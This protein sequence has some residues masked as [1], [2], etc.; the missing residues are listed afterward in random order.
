MPFFSSLP[1]GVQDLIATVVTFAVALAWLRI[2]DTLA[3]RGLIESRLSRKII[4]IGTGP[5][6]LLCWPLFSGEPWARFAAALVPLAITV[7][8]ILLGFGIVK[9]PPAVQ[10]MTR[11]NDPREILRGPVYYGLAFA[12]CTLLFWRDSAV[13]IVALMLLCGG[14]GLADIIG[15]R[16]GSLRLPFN[17]SK[18]WAGSG[19]MFAG[20]FVFALAFVALFYGLG[21]YQTPLGFAAITARVLLIALV[22]ALV[23]ALPL[24]DL[25]NLLVPFAASLLGLWLL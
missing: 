16:F 9:D 15:R 22:A 12:A 23:E 2:I 19:A 14:D 13:G 1:T 21:Y 11:R 17:R 25:D 8:F 4:H 3:H 18:S 6:F 7:Q 5:L 10:A 24:Q 20:G